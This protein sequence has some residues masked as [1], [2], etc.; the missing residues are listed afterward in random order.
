M[1]FKSF[2]KK[3]SIK[4]FF[5][6][7]YFR[8]NKCNRRYNVFSAGQFVRQRNFGYVNPFVAN[9]TSRIF[10]LGIF[11][12]TEYPAFSIW[13]KATGRSFHRVCNLY[14]FDLFPVRLFN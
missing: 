14:N 1:K 3:L 4:N 9:N 10:S 8:D 6:L 2:L 11:A 7:D 5:L 13:F 12:Y